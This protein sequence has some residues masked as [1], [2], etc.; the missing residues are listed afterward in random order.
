[1]NLP[2]LVLALFTP[3]LPLSKDGSNARV[4][5]A[6]FGVPCSLQA[7]KMCARVSAKRRGSIT[8]MYLA[9]DENR[10]GTLSYESYTVSLDS[11]ICCKSVRFQLSTSRKKSPKSHWS[12]CRFAI[13]FNLSSLTDST[14]MSPNQR[15]TSF[16]LWGLAR[17]ILTA[18]HA[19][20]V[21]V[22][23][24]LRMTSTSGRPSNFFYMHWAF[25]IVI[26]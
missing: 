17:R 6:W 26:H 24:L 21:P 20:S 9:S 3:P 5:D 15:R 7:E 23:I 18:G 13:C 4:M 1:M 11:R 8:L 25:I 12:L 2:V 19:N 22:G 14:L 10:S 16:P